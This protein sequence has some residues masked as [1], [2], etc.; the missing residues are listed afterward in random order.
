MD[1]LYLGQAEIRQEDL[2]TFLEVAGEL[3]LK[4]TETRDNKGRD[5]GKDGKISN[6][7]QVT[8]NPTAAVDKSVAEESNDGGLSSSSTAAEGNLL[9]ETPH[10]DEASLLVKDP[11]KSTA[12]KCDECGRTY[13]SKPSLSTHKSFHH[14]RMKPKSSEGR[15]GKQALIEAKE[16]KRSVSE[17]NVK[18]KILGV[19]DKDHGKRGASH[20]QQTGRKGKQKL[21]AKGGKREADGEQNGNIIVAVAENENIP[22]K[23]GHLTEVE[24][25]E[26]NGSGV[27]SEGDTTEGQGDSLVQDSLFLDLDP[28]PAQWRAD[29]LFGK[30]TSSGRRSGS[31]SSSF[32]PNLSWTPPGTADPV[33]DVATA[34]VDALGEID[35]SAPDE[36]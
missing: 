32:L 6:E 16:G 10:V 19:K 12:F 22:P 31:T 29:E 36:Q 24:T 9:V 35:N 27:S 13:G 7:R 8:K 30:S 17:K 28:Q 34:V 23:E 26:F 33:L 14:K 20:S 4:G 11:L 1:F 2:D 25:P 21:E 5:G 15:K 18:K 3:G